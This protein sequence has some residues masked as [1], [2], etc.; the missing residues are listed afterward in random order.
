MIINTRHIILQMHETVIGYQHK[1]VKVSCISYVEI[2]YNYE[3]YSVGNSTQ[4]VTVIVIYDFIIYSRNTRLAI[5]RNYDILTKKGIT[6]V[7]IYRNYDLQN[8]LTTKNMLDIN[9]NYFILDFLYVDKLT[10]VFQ[11]KQLYLILLCL[12]ITY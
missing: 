10:F 4:N 11:F 9:S 12:V 6:G 2:L 1:T 5:Y 3:D 8:V 7:A